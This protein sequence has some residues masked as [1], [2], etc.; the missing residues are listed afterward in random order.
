MAATGWDEV[1]DRFTE[2]GR[3]LKDRWSQHR[4]GDTDAADEVR[5]AVD[6]VRASLDDLADTITR[7]VNDPEVHESARSAASGLVEALTSSLDQLTEK[8]Q[9]RKDDD[10]RP[11]GGSGSAG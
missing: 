1:G 7:T 8:I 5:D 9:P 2:L 10:G 11:G 6:G 3:T 4:E